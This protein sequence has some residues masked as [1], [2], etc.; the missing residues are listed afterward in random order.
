MDH[1]DR[2]SSFVQF[3]VV[4]QLLSIYSLNFP[5]VNFMTKDHT[6]LQWLLGILGLSS[7]KVEPYQVNKANFHILAICL[8]NQLSFLYRSSSDCYQYRNLEKKILH[9][10]LH[11]NPQILKNM[12]PQQSENSKKIKPSQTLDIKLSG[13]SE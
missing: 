5:I 12:I 13:E 9:S 10:H 11:D 1:L 6:R 3:I 2:V 8:I 4:L 7:D